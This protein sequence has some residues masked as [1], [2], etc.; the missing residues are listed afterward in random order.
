MD[1]PKNDDENSF[2]SESE[3]NPDEEILVE[4]CEDNN[5]DNWKLKL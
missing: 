3:V 1:N 2:E 5:L 4:D